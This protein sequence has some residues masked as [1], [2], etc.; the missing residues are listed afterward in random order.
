MGILYLSKNLQDAC[1]ASFQTMLSRLPTV[2]RKDND[3]LGFDCALAIPECLKSAKLEAN[4][5]KYA[6]QSN[7][8]RNGFHPA[9]QIRL[10]LLAGAK[11]GAL[12]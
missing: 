5:G 10:R 9:R 2:Q 11:Q 12:E 1:R 4:L 8:H 3:T 6:R 7:C